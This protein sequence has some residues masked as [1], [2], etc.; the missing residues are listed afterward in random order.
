MK[1]III[2]ILLFT[3]LG[4]SSMKEQKI[5]KVKDVVIEVKYKKCIV[6]KEILNKIKTNINNN[7]TYYE[8]NNIFI[9]IIKEYEVKLDTLKNDECIKVI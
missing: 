5:V 3:A 8:L 2:L 6:N 7:I 1:N 4:C 9:N